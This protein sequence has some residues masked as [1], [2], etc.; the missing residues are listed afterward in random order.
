ME[1]PPRRIWYWIA[2]LLILGAAYGGAVF[3][4]WLNEKAANTSDVTAEVVLWGVVA[5]LITVSVA[6]ILVTLLEGPHRGF[7]EAHFRYSVLVYGFGLLLL[8]GGLGGS[9][10][11]HLLA[12][13]AAQAAAAV[14]TNAGVLGIAQRMSR[15]VA[16]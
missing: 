9:H 1:E 4:D 16:A 2:P 13:G 14:A 10:I 12:Y 3:A 7:W 11:S 8:L 5:Q 6:T 15:R